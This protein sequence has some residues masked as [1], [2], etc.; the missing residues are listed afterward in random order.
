VLQL[1]RQHKRELA[2]A[3]IATLYI[4]GNMV[5][6]FNGIYL[7]N[8][9]PAVLLIVYL[10][11]TRLDIIYFILLAFTPLSVPLFEFVKGTPIDFFIPTEP[12]L[13][14]IMLIVIFRSIQ[15]R[16]LDV[17]IFTH[18][19][20]I[21]ILANLFWLF[22]TSVTS[23]MPLVSFKFLLARLWF[24]TSFYLLAIYLFKDTKNISKAIWAYTI[25]LLIVIAYAWSH[26]FS[27]GITDKEAA[28]WVM[29]PFYRDHTSYG[30][31]LAMIIFPFI[32]MN[33]LKS[34]TL[35]AQLG[36][37]FVAFILTV[38]LVLSYTRAAW[39]SI[40]IS[41]IFLGIILLRI[42]FKYLA[43]TGVLVLFIGFSN[44]HLILK[45]FER[46][47]SESSDNLTEHLQS[48][49]NIA[50]DA[51]NLERINRWASAIRMFEEKPMLGWGPGTYM[52]QYAPFQHSSQRTEISTNFGNMG[53]AHS[54]Y[55]GPL[56][57]SGIFGMLSFL[58]I[59]VLSLITAFRVYNKID[60]KQLK[61]LVLSLI[62]GYITYLFHGGL[63]NFL[64]TDKASSLFWGFIAVFVSL[65]LYYKTPEEESIA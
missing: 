52:F 63:N 46:T 64:D 6:T 4:V 1:F 44:Q 24:L 15:Q 30:A 14:G 29:N 42:K 53:N 50:T 22:F 60:N 23:T 21:A 38:A 35:V 7:F 32:G 37:A 40:F 34:R 48:V 19:V 26:H 57:E 49:T 18:P 10:A 43:L 5:L 45:K 55:I 16:F 39:I 61:R 47:E 28:H 58:A 8:L 12:M 2:L 54:E 36:V 17:K 41:L 11:F 20:S 3:L 59:V 13:F 31:V 9:L 56:S 25:P 65:D 62:L 33:L 51:S 27:F